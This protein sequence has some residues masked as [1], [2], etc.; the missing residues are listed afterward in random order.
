MPL[1]ERDFIHRLRPQCI[2]AP[3][4]I[5]DEMN[6][7]IDEIHPVSNGTR[8]V[9]LDLRRTVADFG[10]D[11]AALL[12]FG[13]KPRGDGEAFAVIFRSRLVAEVGVDAAVEVTPAVEAG[14]LTE[15]R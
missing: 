11:G 4:E 14:T 8:H 13:V 7:A 12:R 15:R 6:L 2:L 5:H 3:A 10:D 1:F 9:V